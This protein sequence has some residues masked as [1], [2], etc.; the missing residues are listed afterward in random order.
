M[1]LDCPHSVAQ[2]TGQVCSHLPGAELIDY[3]RSFAG[4]GQTYDALC[5]ACADGNEATALQ[6]LTVCG[7]CF[8]N[9][10]EEHCWTGIVG[11]PDIRRESSS[12]EFAHRVV[13]VEGL[14]TE[15]FLDLSR[16]Q[17]ANSRSIA[18]TKSGDLLSID[19][20]HKTFSTVTAISE[21]DFDLSKPLSINVSPNGNFVALAETRGQRGTVIDLSTGKPT[22]QLRRDDYHSDVSHF[23]FAFF[24]SHEKELIVHGTEWN[25][26]DI[27]D[28]ATGAL[29]TERSHAVP[30]DS[31]TSPDHYLNYFHGRLTVSPNHNWIADDGW[32]WGPAGIPMT[33]SLREWVEANPWESEDGESKK[34]LCQRWYYW[35][36]P[37]CWTGDDTLAVWGYGEDDEWL[38]PAVRLFDANS[39]SELAWFAGPQVASNDGVTWADTMANSAAP[40][41][42]DKYL[43]ACSGKYG[44]SVWDVAGGTCLLEDP[45]FCPIRY[46][47]GSREFLS[48]TNGNAFQ[49]SRLV[50][51]N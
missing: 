33:W 20:M 44:T 26:L 42:F 25:R 19:L 2:T 27:S 10:E 17:S 6:K 29:L 13:S 39:G 28:P 21:S 5:I 45:S 46:H 8:A 50:D 24:V 31:K 4:V 22:M 37:L 36:S 7:D 30:I 32:V 3:K 48:L 38:I 34:D 14:S 40:L 47:S 11:R 51:N 35:D 43:F 12:L 9:I 41:V 16:V 18:L 23:P 15:S 1:K 49:L